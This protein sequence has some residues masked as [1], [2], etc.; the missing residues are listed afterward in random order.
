ME[1]DINLLSDEQLAR[2]VDLYVQ[3]A[4]RIA[5]I[6]EVT[7]QVSISINAYCFRPNEDYDISHAATIGDYNSVNKVIGSNAVRA[8]VK[9]V[10]RWGADRVE[11]PTKVQALLNAPTVG[12]DWM[13]QGDTIEDAQFTPI[14]EDDD[15]APF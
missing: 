1:Q 7:E 6:R 11:Q 3:R 2:C 8:M 10:D 9:L 14:G 13:P 4:M 5:Q 15:N 12:E